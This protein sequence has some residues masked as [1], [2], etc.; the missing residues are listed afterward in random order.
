MEAAG[1]RSSG[2]IRSAFTL[3]ELLVVIAIIAIL[4]GLLLPALAKAKS[5]AQRTKCVSNLKQI[6]L[7]MRIWA[8][9][10]EGKFPWRVDQAEGGGKYDIANPMPAHAQF[11]LVS[12]E[13]VT[14]KIVACP[15]DKDRPP[16]DSF[17]AFGQNNV[18]YE[19]GNDA[20]QTKPNMILAADRSL[21]GFEFSGLWDN[22][23]CFTINSPPGGQNAKWDS[24]K[25][26]GANMG[27]V[28]FCDGSVQQLN[29]SRL[30]K[31]ITSI[32]SQETIDGTVRLYVP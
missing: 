12:N 23:A 25:C 1:T 31:A 8:N 11:G 32:N 21:S 28:G 24:A 14:P 30:V 27:N 15:S 16:S 20:D 22:T 26:H 7:A 18:S 9:D 5:R 6:D 2:R 4:A 17:K 19:V 10:N 3:I 13:L 29:D